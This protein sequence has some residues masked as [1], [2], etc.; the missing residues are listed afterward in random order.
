MQ[1]SRWRCVLCWWVG[2][3]VGG[4]ER[5]RGGVGVAVR[6]RQREPGLGLP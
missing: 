4:G 3:S 2:G 5:G 1:L 6:V